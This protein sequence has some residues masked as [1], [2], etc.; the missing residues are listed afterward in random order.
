MLQSPR[1]GRMAR[2]DRKDRPSS[3][4][5]GTFSSQWPSQSS[6]EIPSSTWDRGLGCRGTDMA[7]ESIPEKGQRLDLPSPEMAPRTQTLTS[8]FIRRLLSENEFDLFRGK[9]D[10]SVPTLPQGY[11]ETRLP[12]PPGAWFSLPQ[13]TQKFPC[14]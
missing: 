10:S 1:K 9:T 4:N 2:R 6:C 12:V 11:L 14:F 8:L 7:A 3:R 5:V 13:R